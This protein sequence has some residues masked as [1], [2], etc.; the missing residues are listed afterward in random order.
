MQCAV[1]MRFQFAFTISEETRKAFSKSFVITM[2]FRN[3]VQ[4]ILKNENEETWRKGKKGREMEENG[5]K[6][7]GNV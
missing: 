4:M 3:E 2:N 1:V 5:R 7:L 6:R